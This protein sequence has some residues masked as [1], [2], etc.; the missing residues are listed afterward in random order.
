MPYGKFLFTFLPSPLFHKVSIIFASNVWN[1]VVIQM[2][3]KRMSES[4]AKP[5]PE[6]LSMSL[7]PSYSKSPKL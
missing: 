4:D 3:V 2:F 5:G 6:Q 7:T 1:M